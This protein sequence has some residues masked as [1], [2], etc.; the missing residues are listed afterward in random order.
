MMLLVS[1]AFAAGLAVGTPGVAVASGGV[2]AVVDP[3]TGTPAWSVPT[4]DV[5]VDAL[6]WVGTTLWAVGGHTAWTFADG[7]LTGVYGDVVDGATPVR[8]V[9]L[10]GRL[11]VETP[12]Q[13][14][15]VK[16]GLVVGR[17]PT[18]HLGLDGRVG[19]GDTVGAETW[20]EAPCWPVDGG[21]VCGAAGL[22]RYGAGGAVTAV[23]SGS[24]L[25]A[26]GP[27]GLVVGPT[28]T[29]VGPDG[30]VHATFEPADAYTVGTSAVYVARGAEVRAL[31]PDGRTLWA[32]ALVAATPA[33]TGLTVLGET[34]TLVL[35]P[36]TGVL[37][38]GWLGVDL[39]AP[40][41]SDAKSG[42]AVARVSGTKLES[43]DQVGKG[44]H[45]HAAWSV[46]LLDGEKVLDARGPV[47]LQRPKGWRILE[48]GKVSAEGAGQV[49][50]RLAGGWLRVVDGD[51]VTL[52]KLTTGQRIDLKG[53]PEVLGVLDDGS[54]ALVDTELRVV[55]GAGTKWAVPAP[56][57][58]A[59]AGSLVL[60]QLP[61]VLVALRD[62][63]PVW[64]IPF[65]EALHGAR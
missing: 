19:R 12:E 52:V 15:T 62:G 57:H 4:G 20:P 16:D 63:Q 23:L 2:L 43:T 54:V 35:D 45:R 53:S 51:T 65:T 11:L 39:D 8:M 3:V 42:R 29:F 22:R 17:E 56:G 25:L 60:A 33:L 31:G 26:D 64:A 6:A 32:T 27:A 28:P 36:A 10:A 37:R 24:T 14:V 38:G 47:V 50:D 7:R 9:G 13:L 30:K 58:A 40:G 48:A 1:V 59:A 44:R 61:G 49:K 21:A 18:G 41:T 34:T 46:T 55:A 5:R